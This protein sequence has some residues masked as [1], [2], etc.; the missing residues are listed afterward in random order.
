[1]QCIDNVLKYLNYMSTVPN[2]IPARMSFETQTFQRYYKPDYATPAAPGG[3]T[4]GNI[5]EL[6]DQTPGVTMFD[7]FAINIV[8][9]T[10]I[11]IAIIKGTIT[12]PEQLERKLT[13]IEEYVGQSGLAG[14]A[15]NVE[16]SQLKPSRRSRT[17]VGTFALN[18]NQGLVNQIAKD[19]RSAAQILGIQTVSTNKPTLALAQ[20]PKNTGS[21]LVGK[22]NR[23]ILPIN[24][25]L[26]PVESVLTRVSLQSD[27]TENE[28]SFMQQLLDR[29]ENQTE[30]H[31][32]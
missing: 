16:R 30:A 10:A 29:A 2:Q 31:A 15:V 6:A 25:E 8:P 32:L 9:R 27:R 11:A 12:T 7:S 24:V 17:G 1:M 20:C 21:W 28:R 19:R 14:S 3:H 26:T 23:S 22:V 18:L 13:L 5:A 4:F